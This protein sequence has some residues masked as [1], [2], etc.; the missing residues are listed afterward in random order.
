[1]K[2]QHPA[3][4]RYEAEKSLTFLGCAASRILP[5]SLRYRNKT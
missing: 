4:S 5:M 2:L 1:M 3:W